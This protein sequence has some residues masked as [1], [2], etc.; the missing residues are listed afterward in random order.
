MDKINSKFNSYNPSFSKTDKDKSVML[1]KD[2]KMKI[3]VPTTKEVL[4][5]IAEKEVPENGQFRKVFVSFDI[6]NSTNEAKLIIE[7]DETEPKTQRRLS[8][9]VHHQNSDRLISN[10]LLKGTKKEIIDF[11][12]D[13]NNN[14]EIIDAVNILSSKTDDYYSSL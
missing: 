14:Q 12:K 6:P 7:Q 3:L 5:D 9:G 13:D 8:V 1:N 10:Y 2:E 11:L 4:T